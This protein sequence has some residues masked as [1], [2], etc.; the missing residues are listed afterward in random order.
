MAS[1]IV[2]TRMGSKGLK[3]FVSRAVR[4]GRVQRAFAE[5]IGHK[6]GAC[7]RSGVH[8]GMGGAEIRDVV[9]KCG[10]AAKGTKLSL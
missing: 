9:R 7:V 5:Q 6:A 10:G 8:E 1:L 3:I 4:D 2:K